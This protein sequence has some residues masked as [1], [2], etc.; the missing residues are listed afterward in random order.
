MCDPLS[1]AITIGGSLLSADAAGDAADAQVQAGRESN[2]LQYQM[3][4]QSRADQ[5]PWREAGVEALNQLRGG[6]QP[7]GSLMR[8]FG[9]S[10]YQADPGYGFRLAEGM[11]GIERSAAA[12]GNLLSGGALKGIQRYGQDMAS[13]EYQNAYNRFTQNQTNQYNRLA[14]VAGTGQN[15]A[16]QIGAQGMQMGQNVGNTLQGIG[17]ARAS[18]YVGGA[19]ALTGGIG[20]AYNLYNQGQMVNA[21]RD[22]GNRSFDY[23]SNANLNNYGGTGSDNYYGYFGEG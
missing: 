11:K 6:I 3:F 18:G 10:D 9:M 23:G 14:G 15:A 8:S 2:E 13:N 4:N 12:R 7:G 5:A 16:Q 21:L 17:N 19:N 22:K 1:T 20:Q